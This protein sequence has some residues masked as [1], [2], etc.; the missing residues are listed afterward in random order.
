[1]VLDERKKDKSKSW[2]ISIPQQ[3]DSIIIFAAAAE[4]EQLQPNL[5]IVVQ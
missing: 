5:E 4:G 1:M 3:F 2:I